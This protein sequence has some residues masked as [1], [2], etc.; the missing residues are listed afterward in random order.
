MKSF[1]LIAVTLLLGTFGAGAQ[2][3]KPAGKS[4]N[5]RAIKTTPVPVPK[6]LPLIQ[7]ETCKHAVPVEVHTSAKDAVVFSGPPDGKGAPVEYQVF[8][9]MTTGA[10]WQFAARGEISK[11]GERHPLCFANSAQIMVLVWSDTP[12]GSIAEFS[13][14][15]L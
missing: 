13:D 3:T 2:T 12:F 9:Q 8:V 14:T 1:F 6:P 10:A 7:C 15:C 11:P 4:E 5:A